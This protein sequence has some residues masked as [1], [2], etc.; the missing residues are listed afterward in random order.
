MEI[1]QSCAPVPPFPA[2]AQLSATALAFYSQD[3]EENANTCFN[4]PLPS[5]TGFH[6]ASPSPIFG[7]PCQW[8][9]WFGLVCSSP[10]LRKVSFTW[11][12]HRQFSDMV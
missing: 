12:R 2:G 11:R 9:V 4:Q 1:I 7:Y 3:P 10:C 5:E 8:S 6:R